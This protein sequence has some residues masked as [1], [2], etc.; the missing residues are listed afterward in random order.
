MLDVACAFHYH[1]LIFEIIF[2]LY[3][4]R[5][6]KLLYKNARGQKNAAA[7]SFASHKCFQSKQVEI[8][9]MKNN[10]PISF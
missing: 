9:N 8:S 3:K 7:N 10:L 5:V 4:K 2:S 1:I 6:F